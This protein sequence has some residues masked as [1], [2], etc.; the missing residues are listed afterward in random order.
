MKKFTL[1]IVGMTPLLMHR[2]NIEHADRMQLWLKKS[3]NKKAS[4]A[5][6]DRTPGFTWVG[7]LYEHAGKVAIMTEALLKCLSQ[8][9][10]KIIKKKQETYKRVIP[11]ATYFSSLGY[12]LQVHGKEVSYDALVGKLHDETDY[13]KHCE[14]VKKHGFTLF[15][16]RA[17]IGK[18]KHVR[19]RPHF[20]NWKLTATGN[21]DTDQVDTDIFADVVARAGNVGLGDWRPSSGS[22]GQYGVFTAEVKFSK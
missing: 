18:S 3:E 16:K 4:R 19:V 1:E 8:A 14:E 9:G 12:A 21:L 11:A 17:A 5:G 15:A 7:S 2:D 6:D 22:P 13:A 20:D 10:A